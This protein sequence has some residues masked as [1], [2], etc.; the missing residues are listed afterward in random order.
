[1]L[2]SEFQK[3]KRPVIEF[4]KALAG[5]DNFRNFAV[6]AHKYYIDSTWSPNGPASPTGP[7]SPFHP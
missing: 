1:M 6:C 5:L 4:P 2:K 7:T 3:V